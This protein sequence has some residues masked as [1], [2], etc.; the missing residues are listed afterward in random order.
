[1]LEFNTID[2]GYIICAVVDDDAMPQV[3][4]AAN[5]WPCWLWA[6][7][8]HTCVWHV[9]LLVQIMSCYYQLLLPTVRED[10]GQFIRTGVGVFSAAA[11]AA[12]AVGISRD[13]H[14]YQLPGTG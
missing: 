4:H 12:A 7:R 1:M 9:L 14:R 6:L 13:Q 11:A 2:L 3:L 8:E 5:G 10:H